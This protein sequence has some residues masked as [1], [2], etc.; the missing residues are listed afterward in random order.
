MSRYGRSSVTAGET[1]IRVTSERDFRHF[2]MEWARKGG[3]CVSS[4]PVRVGWEWKFSTRAPTNLTKPQRP[5]SARAEPH[6]KQAGAASSIQ[7][8]GLSFRGSKRGQTSQARKNQNRSASPPY[9]E[10]PA[11]STRCKPD[12]SGHIKDRGG[13]FRP[14][15]QSFRRITTW[16][17]CRTNGH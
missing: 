10:S 7:P 16:D 12:S 14:S 11:N 9:P 4:S 5:V 3:G 13:Y 2:G 6:D 17:S 8:A 15:F 1:P